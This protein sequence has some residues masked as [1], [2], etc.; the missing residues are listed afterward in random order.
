MQ[1]NEINP[2][3]YLN[4]VNK[5]DNVVHSFCRILTWNCCNICRAFVYRHWAL[6]TTSPLSTEVGTE[7]TDWSGMGMPSNALIKLAMSACS[8]SVRCMFGK[9]HSRMFHKESRQNWKNVYFL[10]TK[11]SV[12]YHT[13]F[14]LKSYIAWLM[15]IY[16]ADDLWNNFDKEPKIIIIAKLTENMLWI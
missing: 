15:L 4:G 5:I 2:L 3:T 6:K 13:I 11:F 12:K 14:W 8:T 10:F 1:L 16:R 9:F 7:P